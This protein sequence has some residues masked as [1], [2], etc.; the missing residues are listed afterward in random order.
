MN[1]NILYNLIK[2]YYEELENKLNPINW[3]EIL[4][5]YS[6]ELYSARMEV[7]NSV[8]R[9]LNNVI[10]EYV[11]SGGKRDISKYCKYYV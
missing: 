9:L 4:P 5:K 1:K 8:R 7:Q 11:A 6:G 2:K 3:E 10:S